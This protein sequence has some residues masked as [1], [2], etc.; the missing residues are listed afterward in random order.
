MS[1]AHL[2]QTIIRPDHLWIFQLR[3]IKLICRS[4]LSDAARSLVHA[5]VVSRLDHCNG[6]YVNLSRTD[7]KTP[8]YIQCSG[9]VTFGAT[10]YLC[11]PHFLQN[12]LHWL[13]CPERITYKLCLTALK[14]LH[15]M[16]SDNILD[17]CIP[18]SIS[19]RRATLRSTSTIVVG[20]LV[21]SQRLHNTKFGERAFTVAS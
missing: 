11:V 9:N 20:C 5:F 12:R 7:G 8:T 13:R 4:S 6:L 2:G 16:A 21:E 19:G 14:A 3:Q 17:L 1:N 10:R 18:D 15:E